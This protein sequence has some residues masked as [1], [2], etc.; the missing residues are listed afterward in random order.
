MH[1]ERRILTHSHDRTDRRKADLADELTE[2][3][4]ERRMRSRSRGRSEPY[5]HDLGRWVYY[6]SD[7]R[8]IERERRPFAGW[9]STDKPFLLR[10]TAEGTSSDEQTDADE[11]LSHASGSLAKPETGSIDGEERASAIIGPDNVY[12]SEH[13][14][15]H[16]VADVLQCLGLPTQICNLLRVLRVFCSV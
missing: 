15:S 7:A 16:G 3:R 10:N 5:R 9:T 14:R 8:S 1:I 13:L 4:L 12:G 11:N 6:V 2:M